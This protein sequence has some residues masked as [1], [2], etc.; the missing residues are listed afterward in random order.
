MTVFPTQCIGHLNLHGE[1]SVFFIAG[2]TSEQS[3]NDIIHP[4][5]EILNFQIVDEKRYA[6]RTA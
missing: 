2:R 1:T 4:N 5:S 6:H 3:S